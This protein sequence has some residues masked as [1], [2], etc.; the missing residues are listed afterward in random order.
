MVHYPHGALLALGGRSSP[1]LQCSGGLGISRSLCVEFACSPS[2]HKNPNSTL[3]YQSLTGADGSLGSR[4]LRS[5]PL[6]LEGP[7]GRTEDGMGKKAECK[8]HSDLRPA[9]VC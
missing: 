7:G 6:L 2:V 5:C 4:A 8:I 3:S 1:D 9:F